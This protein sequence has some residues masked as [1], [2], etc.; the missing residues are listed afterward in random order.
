V[1][2]SVRAGV[3]RERAAAGEINVVGLTVDEALPR[4][5]KFL[6]D[7]ALDERREVR[8]I[9]GFGQGTGV[10]PA[11][12]SFERTHWSGQSVSVVATLPAA[13]RRLDG[14]SV[15]RGLAP[16]TVTAP[17][18]AGTSMSCLSQMKSFL[19]YTASS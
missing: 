10:G 7:A 1:N 3:K 2:L 11:I 14:R 12:R 9:H 18:A 17:V 16:M 13:D 8:V 15:G 5:D 19:S 6:D 4:V